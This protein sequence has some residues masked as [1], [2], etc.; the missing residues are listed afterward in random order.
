MS[1]TKIIMSNCSKTGKKFC[2]EVKKKGLIYEVVNFIE[3]TGTE[4]E[5]LRSDIDVSNL[6]TAE[7]LIPCRYCGTRKISSCDC[8]VNKKQCTKNSKY[9]FQCIYCIYNHIESANKIKKIYVSRPNYDNIGEILDSL[10]LKYSNMDGR[11]DSDIIFINCGTPERIDPSQIRDFVRQGGCLY[12]SD[13][14]AS[15]I[16]E[17]FPGVISYSKSGS[18]CDIYADVIDRELRQI[19]GNRIKIK[20]DLGGWALLNSVQGN[21]LLRASVGSIYAGRPIM[22]SFKF[23]KGTVFYTSFHNHKQADEKEKMLLQLLLMKQVGS[24][25]NMSIEQVG[26]MIGLNIAILRKKFKE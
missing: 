4:A 17:A 10:G 8:S 3:V 2:S 25:Y 5:K 16:E 14:A 9:D 20:F 21:V 11:F 19:T 26:D 24:S 1:D 18:V 12:A 7:N 13:W 6:V 23:G 15:Y 22:I